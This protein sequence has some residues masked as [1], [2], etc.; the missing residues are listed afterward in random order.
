MRDSVQ[1]KP[2]IILIASGSEVHLALGAADVLE[3]KGIRVRVVSMPSWELFDRQPKAYRDQVLPPETEARLAVEAGVTQGWHKY[4][5]R[6]GEVVGID[7]FGASAPYKILYEK[8][9]L[10]VDHVV[11]RALK[12]MGHAAT[13]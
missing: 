6:S 7:H 13:N 3:K 2:D 1:A 4:V 8:F 12:V 5:G 11:E 9:G 10:T